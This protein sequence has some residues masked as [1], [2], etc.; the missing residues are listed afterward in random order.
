MVQLF[1][2]RLKTYPSTI[3]IRYKILLITNTPA[4]FTAAETP[5]KVISLFFGLDK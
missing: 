4:Y 3:R 2:G 1:N 5:Q